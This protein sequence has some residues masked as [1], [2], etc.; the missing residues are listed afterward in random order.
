MCN[1]NFT[2]ITFIKIKLSTIILVGFYISYS[3]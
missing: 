2:C 3:Y 1:S